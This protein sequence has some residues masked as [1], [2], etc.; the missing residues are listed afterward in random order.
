V[1]DV[2]GDE[3]DDGRQDE[4]HE[5]DAEL[6]EVPA[7]DDRAV[8]P[9]VPVSGGK[10]NQSALRTPS[11]FTRSRVVTSPAPGSKEVICPKTRSN[12]NDSA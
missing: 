5:G 2:L 7:G 10:P 3:R 11:Q 12:T 4:Q 9:V 1:P 6:G 8:G